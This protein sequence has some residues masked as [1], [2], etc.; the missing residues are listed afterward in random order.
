MSRYNLGSDLN[1]I[2]YLINL[3][4]EYSNHANSFTKRLKEILEANKIE[5][6]EIEKNS[7]NF[8]FWGLNFIIQPEIEFDSD[9]H[10]FKDGEFNTYLKTKDDQLIQVISYKF[11]RIGNIGS[12]YLLKDF[13]KIYYIEFV[14]K[15]IALT[16]QEKIKFQLS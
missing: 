10:T 12:G 15:L 7:F 6:T 16:K 4:N 13:A 3:F 8:K 5:T 2:E 14:S 1:E 9:A 11:D